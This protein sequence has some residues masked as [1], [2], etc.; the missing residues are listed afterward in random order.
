M[1]NTPI[2]LTLTYF[3]KSITVKDTSPVLHPGQVMEM[4]K[5]IMISTFGQDTWDSLLKND[6]SYVEPP[7]GITDNE[8]VSNTDE[9]V[10]FNREDIIKIASM[11]KDINEI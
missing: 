9:D 1:S 10:M 3:G 11:F 7:T 5:G 2:V 4:F 8:P 6:P